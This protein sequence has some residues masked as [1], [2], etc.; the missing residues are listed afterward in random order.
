MIFNL[1]FRSA[2]RIGYRWAGPKSSNALALQC[3]DRANRPTDDTVLSE[4]LDRN[5]TSWFVTAGVLMLAKF[6]RGAGG[7]CGELR[8][9]DTSVM[10]E[11]FAGVRGS[12]L[13]ELLDLNHTSS[14]MILVSLA[15]PKFAQDTD[16]KGWRTS[17]SGH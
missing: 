2:V 12:G 3:D 16:G 6:A 1:R 17:G 4:C 15:I 5:R 14:P 9:R 7:K 11:K 10:I 8:D 13:S